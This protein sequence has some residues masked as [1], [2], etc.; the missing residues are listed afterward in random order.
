MLRRF[1]FLGLLS[2]HAW[3]LACGGGY[4]HEV[5][6]SSDQRSG[7]Y[8]NIIVPFHQQLIFFQSG[9]QFLTFRMLQIRPAPQQRGRWL[10]YELEDLQGKPF[11]QG[12]ILLRTITRGNQLFMEDNVITVGDIQ[13][14]IVD[15]FL[16]EVHVGPSQDTLI[17]FVDDHIPWH[18]LNDFSEI[19][20]IFDDSSTPT[21]PRR[22]NSD[23][24]E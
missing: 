13:F 14:C 17:G 15:F 10:D 8:Q 12:S 3:L 22:Q 20:H 7:K 19:S 5:V 18:T 21:A 11:F 9:D 4:E 23:D 6:L 16:E 2:A 24:D 1:W